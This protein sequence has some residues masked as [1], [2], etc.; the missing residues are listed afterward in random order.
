MDVKRKE[1]ISHCLAEARDLQAAGN[2]LF[3]LFQQH[4]NSQVWDLLTSKDAGGIFEIVLV[5]D[6]EDQRVEL[7]QQ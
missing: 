4:F 6:C 7:V 2:L 3:R 5:R 1:Y